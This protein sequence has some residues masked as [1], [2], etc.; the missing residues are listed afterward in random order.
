[1]EEKE[2]T[3]SLAWYFRAWVIIAAILFFGPLGLFL[4]W[5]RPKTKLRIKTLVSAIVI[6]VTIWMSVGVAKYYQDIVAY[7][8]KL[9]EITAGM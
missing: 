6:A 2:K 4:L 5:F 1:M 9:A 3:V 8:E 7:Y